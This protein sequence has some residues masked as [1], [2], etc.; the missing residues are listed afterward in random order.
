MET[1]DFTYRK[2]QVA[3]IIGGTSISKLLLASELAATMTSIV[4]ATQPSAAVLK[5]RH[6][7]AAKISGQ[8]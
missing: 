1:H 7:L 5:E 2:G 6:A 4:P 8:L 3:V